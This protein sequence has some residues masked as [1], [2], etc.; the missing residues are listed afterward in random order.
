MKNTLMTPTCF[1]NFLIDAAY[2]SFLVC[3]SQFNIPHGLFFHLT[4]AD[5]F[6]IYFTG[7]HH[8]IEREP[9]IKGKD[10]WRFLEDCAFKS[11]KI[12]LNF[13]KVRSILTVIRQTCHQLRFN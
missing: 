10:F 4:G 2:G 13:Y 1:R 12:K 3:D 8:F 6:C 7:H 11:L 5:K 9:D